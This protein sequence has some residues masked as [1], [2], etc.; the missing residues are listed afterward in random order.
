MGEGGEREGGVRGVKEG[1]RERDMWVVA[2]KEGGMVVGKRLKKEGG[3]KFEI[4]L[5]RWFKHRLAGP[6]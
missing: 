6:H 2:E 1:K 5:A 3:R 4:S